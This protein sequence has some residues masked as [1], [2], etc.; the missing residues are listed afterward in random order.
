M[1]LNNAAKAVRKCLF[2]YILKNLKVL[3]IILE[4]WVIFYVLTLKVNDLSK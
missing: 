1:S 3:E 2:L 4:M